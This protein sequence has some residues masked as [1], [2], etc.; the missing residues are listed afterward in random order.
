MK[1]IIKLISLFSKKEKQRLF[2]I[3]FVIL[4]TSLLNILEIGSVAPF[5][6]VAADPEIVNRQPQL[7]FVYNFLGFNKRAGSNT[8]FL[9]FLGLLIFAAL[10][11]LT[12]VRTGI[13]YVTCR[14]T[15]NRRYTISV[16][17]FRQYLFQPYQF[18]LNK[19]SGELSKNVLSEVDMVIHAVMQPGIHI[20]T[21]GMSALV[22]LVFLVILNP[23]VAVIAAVIFV[24]LYFGLYV[25]LRPRLGRFGKLVREANKK[26]F[27]T[28]AEAFG[29][30]KDVKI[31]GK[32]Y[33][34]IN[35]Y[36]RGAKQF[37][38]TQAANQI[39]VTLPEQIVQSLTI[40]FAIALMI[41]LLV[42]RGTLTEILP[43]L[44]VYALAV[45]RL[46]P[47]FQQ[48][49]HGVAQL[50]FSAPTIDALYKDMT[51]LALPP[52]EVFTSKKAGNA[53]VE[54]MPFNC[55]IELKDIQ[56]SY[57]ASREPVLKGINLTI[58]KNASAAF[59]GTTGCG[60]TTLVDVIMGLLEP[61]AGSV[62]VDGFPVIIPPGGKE[63]G[64][65]IASWQ[66][67]FG[68]VPQHIYLSDNSIAANIAFGVPENLRDMAAVENAAKTANL[69]NFIVN[70]LPEG[71]NTLT[72]E[73]GVRLSGGQR[74]RIGIAR[75]LYHDPN[76][77]VMDE[78]TSA[79]DS[80]TEDAVMDAIQNLM[81]TKTVIIIAHRLTTIKECDKIYLI[82]QGKI[83]ASGT[84][85]E[86]L[87][88]SAQF[89]AMAKA[90]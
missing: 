39:Y 72:G 56:F 65:G 69:H 85:E 45:L 12:A 28:S 62:N 73:R 18:F 44:S 63:S 86:L 29:G 36:A 1:S 17:L 76:I 19:N 77:L 78:A 48:I 27:K 43:L 21:N 71:Y 53:A 66:R 8:D 84:Y 42:T 35:D 13:S 31:L 58:A 20:F 5:M 34:F 82:E 22:I 24:A 16:R 87:Q 37:A 40:G 90:K 89:R 15:A 51:E 74:Q 6:A 38:A 52:N 32:E 2:L 49:F 25:F 79:L 26:R 70:E 10:I 14:Y 55:N 60:K 4:C 46:R 9:V 61:S 57:T 3:T 75:A 64:A 7:A 50:R 33:F 54:A 23:L 47:N 83:A 30:I 80:I 88:N 11:L 59:A 81:H 41:I 67:N 68:Y